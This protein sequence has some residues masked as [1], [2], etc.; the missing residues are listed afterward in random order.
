MVQGAHLTTD[1][2]AKN[3]EKEVCSTESETCTLTK[4]ESCPHSDAVCKLLSAMDNF[5]FGD[6]IT[7]TQCVMTDSSTLMTIVVPC[8]DNHTKN[9]QS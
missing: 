6:E 1:F 5:E 8:E 2:N 3:L 4:C 7:Y 9:E